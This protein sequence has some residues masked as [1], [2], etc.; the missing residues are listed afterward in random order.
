MTRISALLE[1]LKEVERIHGDVGV[2]FRKQTVNTFGDE[3]KTVDIL[4][5]YARAGMLIEP[6]GG[7]HVPVVV[8]GEATVLGKGA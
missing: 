8:I 5:L 4:N 3:R 6:V 7:S 2:V 1:T